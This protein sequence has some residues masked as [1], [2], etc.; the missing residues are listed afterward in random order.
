MRDHYI[1]VYQDRYATSAV[2]KYLD[3]ATVN[4]ST[5]FYKT[6]FPSDM[7]LTKADAYTSDEIVMRL[8]R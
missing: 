6:N 7:I 1:Y 5:K 4:T 8:N 2:V 3:T